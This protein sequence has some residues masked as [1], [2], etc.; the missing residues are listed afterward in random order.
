VVEVDHE[1]PTGRDRAE[2][3]DEIVRIAEVELPATAMTVTSGSPSSTNSN[4]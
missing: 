2:L 3:L 4:S 1:R